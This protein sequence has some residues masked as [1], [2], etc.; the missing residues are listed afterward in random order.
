MSAPTAGKVKGM[1]GWSAQK[2]TQNLPFS[3]YIFTYV[4]IIQF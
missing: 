2:P 3:S 1:T 4:W